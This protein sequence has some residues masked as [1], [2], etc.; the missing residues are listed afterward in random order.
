MFATMFGNILEIYDFVAYG[1]FAVPISKTFFPAGNDLFALILTL[2]T[3]AVGFL[4]RPIGALVI[5]RYADRV[6][7]KKALSLTLN[8]MGLGTLVMVATPPTR[9]SASLRRALFSWAVCYRVFRRVVKL[10]VP[11]HLPSKVSQSIAGRS[12]PRSRRR[13]KAQGFC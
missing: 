7:R 13:R 8:M 9:Q 2:V 4:A 3:F 12:H 6:G 1:I 5:G 10:E 11:S